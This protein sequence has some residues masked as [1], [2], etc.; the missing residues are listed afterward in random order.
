M[1]DLRGLRDL[2][3][4]KVKPAASVRERA[5]VRELDRAIERECVCAREIDGQIERVRV[6]ERDR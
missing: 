1:K 4:Q 2:T 3:I 6:C 5:C